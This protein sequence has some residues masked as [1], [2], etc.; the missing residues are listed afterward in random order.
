M[1]HLD[2]FSGIG[3]FALATEMVWENVEHVF[4]DNDPFAQSV[5]KKHYPHSPIYGD[6][7]SLTSHAEYERTHGKD[8]DTGGAK[9]PPQKGRQA[10][11][12][13]HQARH[14]HPAPVDLLTGGFP[15]QPFSQAGRRRGTEDD[16]YL[17]PEML[18]V[19][20]EF[21]PRWVIAENV[22]G[23]IT[24][25]GGMVFE[26]VCIDLEDE[27]Y[28]VQAFVIPA[29]GVNAPH[30]R[31]RVWI[32]AHCDSGRL[33]DQPKPKRRSEGAPITLNASTDAQYWAERN[34]KRDRDAQRT[35]TRIARSDPHAAHKSGKGLEG[36]RGHKGSRLNR[37]SGGAGSI[38]GRR[39]WDQNWFEVAARLCR[40]DDGIP[41]G[42]DRA[43]RIKA[44]GNAIVPQVATEIM[45]AIKEADL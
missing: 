41:K 28:G 15:C 10:S 40:V 2:L 29:A 26:Q 12:G 11:L 16:R 19:I 4:C 27:G 30:R 32:V 21:H 35:S 17:W 8:G 33:R 34:A 39:S 43:K 44:L 38:E 36:F 13:P 9:S 42:V 31:D 1:R 7:R 22:G 25:S 20:H 45:R 18:R 23:L 3:G 5:L 37:K 24:W 14:R 6:I